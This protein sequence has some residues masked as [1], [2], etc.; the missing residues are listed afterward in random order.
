MC[1]VLV[2]FFVDGFNVYHALR[3]AGRDR[4][5]QPGEGASTVGAEWFD[6][7]RYCRDFVRNV[8]PAGASLQG[9]E[10]FTAYAT[11][12]QP[13]QPDVVSRHMRYVECLEDL[14]VVVTVGRFKAVTGRHCAVCGAPVVRHE[15]KETDVAIAASMMVAF[16]T[17][18]CDMAVLVTGDTDM[19]PAIRAARRAFVE[20]RIGILFPYGRSHDELRRLTDVHRRTS[21]KQCFAFQLPDP[22]VTSGGR[23]IAKPTKW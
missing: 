7:P 15:E 21:L 14:G 5:R 23:N 17:D 2:R 9:I 1:F 19:A 10:Y 11:H 13:S 18:A 6:L 4:S 8:L 12:L 20:K 3:Q 22:L 16:A